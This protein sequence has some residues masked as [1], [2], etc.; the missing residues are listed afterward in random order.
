VVRSVVTFVAGVVSNVV[1][2]AVVSLA[3]VSL[4]VVSIAVV[5]VAVVSIAVV[6][7]AESWLLREG[8][9]RRGIASSAKVSGTSPQ[10]FLADPSTAHSTGS[11]DVTAV[12]PPPPTPHPP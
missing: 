3:V 7:I 5:S 6:S 11:H 12:Y 1:S 2:L 8:A 10:P 9:P 4:A